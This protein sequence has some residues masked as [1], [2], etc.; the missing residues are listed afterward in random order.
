VT[1]VAYPARLM[2]VSRLLA[3]G[4]LRLAWALSGLKTQTIRLGILPIVLA[5]VTSCGLHL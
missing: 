3:C 2:F 5:L 4:V 1:S